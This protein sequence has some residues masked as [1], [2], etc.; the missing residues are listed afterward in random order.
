[1]PAALREAASN[2]PAAALGAIWV[3]MN[4]ARKQPS[5]I[6]RMVMAVQAARGA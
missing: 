5:R 3:Q 4:R 2:T 1:M 6:S